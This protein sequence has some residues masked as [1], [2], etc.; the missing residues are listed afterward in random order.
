MNQEE[1]KY[2]TEWYNIAM[3]IWGDTRSGFAIIDNMEMNCTIETT[4]EGYFAQVDMLTYENKEYRG[5]LISGPVRTILN[6][7]PSF[8]KLSR[9]D[10]ISVLK[11][12]ALHLAISGHGRRFQQMAAIVGANIGCSDLQDHTTTSTY[13]VQFQKGRGKKFR[14]WATLNN[15][16]EAIEL[17]TKVWASNHIHRFTQGRIIQTTK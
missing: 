13:A 16:P 15:L 11:H 5:V 9:R 4:E 12:E 17:Q 14:T 10:Q 2:I 3:K 6:L 7:G 1:K 8:L